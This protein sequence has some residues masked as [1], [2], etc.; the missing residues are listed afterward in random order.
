MAA[1]NAYHLETRPAQSR[2]NFGR[3]D[4]AT[5]SFV[6]RYSLNTNKPGFG[7]RRFLDVKAERD[8]LLD[9]FDENV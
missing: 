6:N 5:G 2:N 3:G 1:P 8:R 9:S 7:R 4:G